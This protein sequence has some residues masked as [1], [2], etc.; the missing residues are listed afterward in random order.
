MKRKSINTISSFLFFILILS[1]SGIENDE[2]SERVKISFREVGNQLLLSHQDSTSLILPVV[3]LKQSKYRL[4]FQEELSF[5]PSNLVSFIETNFKK[6]NLP[7]H[8]LVEVI[9]CVD[10]EVAYSYEMSIDEES[11]IIPCMSR[12]LPLDCY[13]IEVRFTR[14]VASLMNKKTLLYGSVLAAFLLLLFLIYRRKQALKNEKQNSD[15]IKVGS[16]Q[17]YQNQNKLIKEAVE[18]ALS[19][20]ECELLAIFVANPNQIITRD[21]LTKRVWEDNGVV[22]GRSL[23][24]FISKLRK[25]L[26]ADSSII[27]ENVHG[28]GYKLVL[29]N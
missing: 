10:D 23:D 19:K 16:F 20:K 1:C 28:V 7:K 21:E 24:T 13:Y 5:E 3:A 11:T 4:S 12:N 25:K 18:I 2:F 9:Q 14:R 8:Y 29:V 27:I 22:V 6:A 17:F 15:Y 26:S